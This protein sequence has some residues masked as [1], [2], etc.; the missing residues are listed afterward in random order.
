MERAASRFDGSLTLPLLLAGMA[1]G[2]LTTFP[3]PQNAV[4][5]VAGA[6]F[7][8]AAVNPPLALGALVASVPMQDIGREM[9]GPVNLTL[10]KVVLLSIATSWG[11]RIL[12]QRRPIRLDRLALAYAL[13]VVV[14]GLSIV[15]APDGSSWGTELYRWWSP[16]LAYVIATNT[17]GAPN[18]GRWIIAGTAGGVLGVSAY[19]VAQVV[20][21]IGP[22]SFNVNGL[23]RAY[24]TFGQPNPFAG[25]LGLT[26]PF[27]V[28][29][30]AWWVVAGRESAARKTYP[31]SL[32]LLAAA[33]AG[34][35]LLAL[36]L[37]QSRGGWLGTAA[38]LAA[39]AWLLGRRMRLTAAAVGVLALL[40]VVVTPYGARLA[41]R[42]F[43]GASLESEAVLV[44]PEN[45]AVQERLAHWRA[46]LAMA[47]RYPYLGVGAGSY[48]AR[49][50]EFTPEWR[51]RISRGHAHSAFVQAAA[52]SGFLGLGAYLL[53]W[54]GVASRLFVVWRAAGDGPTKPLVVGAIGVSV[55]FAVHNVF[56][57]LHVLSLPV[58]LAALWAL[59]GTTI[60]PVAGPARH[61]AHRLA[62]RTARP[63][64]PYG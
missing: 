57:Y 14:L 55:A 42:L 11:L 17:I 52:Q 58:Q 36:V 19:G 24:A 28:A 13:Y 48:S 41:G 22:E 59:A 50:R 39:V 4:L 45:F 40:A 43:E 53:F 29:L 56:D 35:G 27:L 64:A 62:W 60:S 49:F 9:L 61:V 10:T 2:V 1:A 21:G 30:V 51:F 6:A 25:Y 3:F 20:R 34:L 47:K 37:T 18:Q 44:T 8:V 15:N 33:A 54:G 31:P 38:G 7:V 26:V 63:A 23:Q 5:V 16:L 12:V 46:G 32:I